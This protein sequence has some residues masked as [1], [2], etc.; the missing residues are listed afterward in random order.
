MRRIL[1]ICLL[2]F[3]LAAQGQNWRPFHTGQRY[4][5]WVRETGSNQPSL[6]ALIALN[7]V[8][9]TA[10]DSVWS[11]PLT[12]L[13]ST[14]GPGVVGGPDTLAGRSLVSHSIFGTSVAFGGGDA[15]FY[16]TLPSRR[17]NDSLVLRRNAPI[18]IP[19]TTGTHI[20]TLYSTGIDT[21][22]G[23]LDSVRRYGVDDWPAVW[24]KTYGIVNMP[25]LLEMRGRD[26]GVNITAG[27][28]VEAAILPGGLG[29][30]L[31]TVETLYPYQPGDSVG[32][33]TFE[34]GF[35]MGQ[36]YRERSDLYRFISRRID[37]VTRQLILG[38]S[39]SYFQVDYP[40]QPS[41]VVDANSNVIGEWR[42]NLDSLF[43]T[44][45]TFREGGR[46]R[47]WGML[48]TFPSRGQMALTLQSNDAYALDST[49]CF[50]YNPIDGDGGTYIVTDGL[51]FTRWSVYYNDIFL[52]CYRFNGQGIP[53]GR[54]PVANRL[55]VDGGFRLAANPVLDRAEVVSATPLTLMLQDT[56]GRT[57][58][59]GEGNSLSTQ[60][61]PAGLYLLHMQDRQGRTG[62]LRV[63]R[64]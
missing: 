16:S 62:L 11:Y 10:G 27:E 42:L 39:Y 25:T 54:L 58:A 8:A 6:Y 61:L 12:F 56:Q 53:C 34:S 36:P 64:R 55:T 44:G 52:N 48:G 46:T 2:G 45:V 21:V 50:R 18:G 17:I 33:S 30:R 57:V 29:M 60:N 1:L 7:P 5:Y 49:G 4:G 15:T 14:C 3:S 31:P 24:S 41:R 43:A 26:F 28:R 19:Y 35:T 38:Y 20:V 32:Y 37:S 51:G 22:L 59:S 13:D 40:F 23:V 47:A 63:V 9:R